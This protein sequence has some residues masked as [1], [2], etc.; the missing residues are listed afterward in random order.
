MKLTYNG[1]GEGTIEKVPPSLCRLKETKTGSGSSVKLFEGVS[2][3]PS[4]YMIKL[5]D[6]PSITAP[7]LSCAQSSQGA[8]ST[9][10]L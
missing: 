3:S 2:I 9:W 4:N 7:T 5:R 8:T 10:T 6:E 1:G